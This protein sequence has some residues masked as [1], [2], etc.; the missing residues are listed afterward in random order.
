MEETKGL[1]VKSGYSDKAIEYYLKKINVGQIENPTVYSYYIGPCGNTM[2]IY[3]NVESNVIKDAKF[4]AVGCAGTF[5]SGAALIDIVKGM[6]LEKAKKISENHIVKFLGG[7]PEQKIHCT[8]LARRTLQKAIEK[9]ES[10]IN[11][12]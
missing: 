4:Q 2:E 5:S 12:F 8:T 7:M 1:L 6:E 10:K 9:Y 11:T 3:L